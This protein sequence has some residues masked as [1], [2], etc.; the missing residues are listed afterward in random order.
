MTSFSA[1][2]QEHIEKQRGPR[3][4]KLDTHLGLSN[5]VYCTAQTNHTVQTNM[6]K[7]YKEPSLTNQSVQDYESTRKDKKRSSV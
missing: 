3:T 2:K 5:H 7:S 1:A 4:K 6:P